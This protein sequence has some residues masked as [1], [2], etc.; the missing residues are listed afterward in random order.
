MVMRKKLKKKKVM[1]KSSKNKVM[2]SRKN[3]L[4]DIKRGEKEREIYDLPLSSEIATSKI[5]FE[6]NKNKLKD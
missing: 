4:K 5:Q 6:V 3:I 2:F 1:M